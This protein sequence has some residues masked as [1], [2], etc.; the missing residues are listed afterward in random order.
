MKLRLIMLAVMTAFM[1]SAY[2][3]NGANEVST[4]PQYDSSAGGVGADI[5]A[6]DAVV[7]EAKESGEYIPL[8]R[9]EQN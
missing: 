6:A 8:D 2:A 1:A 7:T 5:A 3:N 9:S 4:A